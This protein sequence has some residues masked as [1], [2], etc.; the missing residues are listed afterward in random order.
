MV[1]RSTW[2][3]GTGWPYCA[4]TCCW[5]FQEAL[6]QCGLMDFEKKRPRTAGARDFENWAQETAGV[7]LIKPIG[8]ALILPGDFLIFGN[9]SHIGISVSSATGSKVKTMEG[10]TN[11]AGGREG[12]GFWMKDRNRSDF[13]SIVRVQKEFFA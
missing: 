10:N 6:K 13:R 5:A 3:D 8:T 12:D 2:L 7:Q 4:A 11:D 9:I 1:Q